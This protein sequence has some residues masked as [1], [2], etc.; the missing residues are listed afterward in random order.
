MCISSVVLTQQGI[1]NRDEMAKSTQII[2]LLERRIKHGDYL[3]KEVPAEREL[4]SEFGVNSLTVRKAYIRLVEKGLL[5]KKP[6]GRLEVNKDN[7]NRQ[8]QIAFVVPTF[9]Q[10][11]DRWR[12]AVERSAT[13]FNGIVR[14]IYFLHW[15]DPI[16]VNDL[17]GFDGVF[18]LPNYEPIPDKLLEQFQ[19]R[20]PPVV[21]LDFDLSEYGIPSLDM[22][23]AVFVQH[24]LDHLFSLGHTSIHCMN[25]QQSSAIIEGRIN[26]WNIWKVSHGVQG[27]LISREIKNPYNVSPFQGGYDAMK[28]LLEKQPACSAIICTTMPCAI[29]A[30]RA[31][32]EAGIVVGKDLSVCAVDGEGYAPF[33]NP[34]VTSLENPDPNPYLSVC[35]EWMQR[36]GKNWIGPLK[37]F[38]TKPTIFYGDSTGQCNG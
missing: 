12:V 17:A 30:M 18:L 26:Q 35:L 20:T 31:C 27:E 19:N 2:E 11:V 36:S 13:A 7:P 14:P 9:S 25:V 24:L 33:Q 34:S 21:S 29:G 1:I 10:H 5:T 3:I 38:P 15:D 28:Q 4:A 37:M 6:N 8:M 22:M 16:M 32:A 23:P